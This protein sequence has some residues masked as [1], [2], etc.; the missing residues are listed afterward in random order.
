[1]YALISDTNISNLDSLNNIITIDGTLYLNDNTSISLL[2]LQNLTSIGGLT[3]ND[4]GLNHFQGL[5][6]LEI[7]HGDLRIEDCYGISTLGLYSLTGIQG[8]LY[9]EVRSLRRHISCY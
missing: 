3:I 7:I 8:D 1:M 5:E 9:L 6:N 2:G 4:D